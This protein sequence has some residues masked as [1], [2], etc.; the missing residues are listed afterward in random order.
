MSDKR[1]KKKRESKGAYWMDTYGDMVTLLLTFFVM[2]FA[3]S[4]MNESKWMRIVASFTGEPVGTVVEPI[5]PLNPTN[6]FTSADFIP[7][8]EPRDKADGKQNMEAQQAFNELY[9]KLKA[10]IE[11]Q[12]LDS[13]LALE[14]DGQ[15]IYVT[16]PDRVFFDSGSAQIKDDLARQILI[17]LGNMFALEWDSVK[18]LRVEGHTDSDLVRNG[19]Y[20]DNRQLSQA[21][22]Y[23]VLHYMQENTPL[24][25]DTEEGAQGGR[26]EAIGLAETDPVAPNDTQDG[27]GRNR[28]VEFVLESN[29]TGAKG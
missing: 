9:E 15:I 2:M 25:K 6:G 19:P 13:G 11:A 8:T 26:I 3:S 28:R 20:A 12:G 24:P 18:L 1:Q 5:D 29:Y 27:K 21:R 4:T 16:V 14:K 22:A 17:D 7:K 10:Y 23:E